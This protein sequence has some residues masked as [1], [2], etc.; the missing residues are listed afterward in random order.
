MRFYEDR[1]V[2]EQMNR[3]PLELQQ[4]YEKT[5]LDRIKIDGVEIHGYFEYSFLEEKSYREQ[6][7]R[8][9]AGVIE[10]L[11][12][13]ATFLTPRL[14]IKYNMMHIDDYRKLMK[15]L[16]SKNEFEVECYDIVEDKRVTHRMYFAPPQMPII[17]QQY[18]MALGIQEYSIELIGTNSTPTMKYDFNIPADALSYF[19]TQDPGEPLERD[20][21]S[22]G[23]N[24]KTTIGN[25]AITNRYGS[26]ITFVNAF[27]A[28]AS[29]PQYAFVQWNTR[30]DGTGVAYADNNGYYISQNTTLYAQ[31][32]LR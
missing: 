9:D 31:W 23:Y 25:L 14:I 30:K 17:Y 29:A 24:T 5:Q 16:K 6:P 12:S 11:D 7:V 28:D 13:Y 1:S 15:L 4:Y 26:N 10:D 21:V 8:S 20:G 19:K 32:E 27:T 18:L 3:L 22:V 2:R